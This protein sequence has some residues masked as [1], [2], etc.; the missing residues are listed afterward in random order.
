MSL[1]AIQI[2]NRL[3]QIERDLGERQ[4]PYATAAEDMHKLAREYEERHARAFI[5]AQ[6]DTATEKKARAVEALAA[7]ED[8]IWTRLAE[9]EGAYEGQ[10]AAVKVLETRATIGMSLLKGAVREPSH[11]PSGRVVGGMGAA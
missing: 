8:G 7:A 11:V 4:E 10:R 6:G 9:A 5:A 3:E 2:E 1:S